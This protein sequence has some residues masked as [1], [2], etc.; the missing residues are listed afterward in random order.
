VT[1][2]NIFAKSN[3]LDADYDNDDLDTDRRLLHRLPGIVLQA[4]VPL[5]PFRDYDCKH[6]TESKPYPQKTH[7]AFLPFHT[8]LGILPPST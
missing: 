7:N 8:Y 2:A 1:V 6:E 5:R 3:K 4:V